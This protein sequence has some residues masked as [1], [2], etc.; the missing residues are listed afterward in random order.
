MHRYVTFHN[1]VLTLTSNIVFS[2]FFSAAVIES[3]LPPSTAIAFY[4][5]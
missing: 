3:F 5:F 1:A 4:W 2:Q